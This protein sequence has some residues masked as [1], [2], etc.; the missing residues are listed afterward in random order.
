MAFNTLTFIALSFL[1]PLS[2]TAKDKRFPFPGEKPQGLNLHALVGADIQVSPDTRI[3]SGVLLIR[4]GMIEKVEKGKIVPPGYRKWDMSGK[5]V[6]PGFID[7]YLLTGTNAG[8][9]LDLRHDHDHHVHATA[10]L[11]FH[12]TPSTRPDPGEK[13]PGFEVSGVHPERRGIEG[14]QPDEGKWKTLRKHGF[15]VAHLAPSEGILRGTGPCV[16]LGQGDP[17]ELAIKEEVA[18]LSLI[19]I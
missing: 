1:V 18:Q 13:G 4:D 17:N 8:K 12:G 6:Y 19:H 10:D 16:L 15:T 5:T 9:L 3:K 14:F 2:L 7:P 11:S